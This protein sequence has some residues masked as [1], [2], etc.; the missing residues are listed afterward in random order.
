[1]KLE[2]IESINTDSLAFSL[3]EAKNYLH[4]LRVSGPV[5]LCHFL[6]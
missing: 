3:A 2:F 5:V 6:T 1:M 4:E